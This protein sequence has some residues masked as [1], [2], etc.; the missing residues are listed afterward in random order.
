MRALALAVALALSAWLF[1]D[2]AVSR[3]I[4]WVL[5]AAAVGPAIAG[6]RRNP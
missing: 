2:G 4:V 6:M 5:A 1:L 3:A